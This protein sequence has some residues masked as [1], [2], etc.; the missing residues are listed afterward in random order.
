MTASVSYAALVRRG[1][2][3]SFVSVDSI[4]QTETRNVRHFPINCT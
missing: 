1:D 3:G 2:T 4:D